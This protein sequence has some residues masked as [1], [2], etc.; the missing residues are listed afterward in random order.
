MEY[1]PN[2]GNPNTDHI[3]LRIVVDAGMIMRRVM[4]KE[5]NMV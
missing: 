4:R 5:L 1:P 3:V 2:V